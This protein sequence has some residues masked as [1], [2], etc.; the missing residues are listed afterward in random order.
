M[1]IKRIL[2]GDLR[3]RYKFCAA[4]SSPH[5]PKAK[6]T[7]VT[8]TATATSALLFAVLTLAKPIWLPRAVRR[9]RVYYYIVCSYK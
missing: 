2:K 1:K 5:L 3:S 6:P 7:W 4:A 9:G 8:T